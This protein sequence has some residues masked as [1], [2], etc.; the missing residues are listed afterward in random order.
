[1]A[2]VFTGVV[3]RAMAIFSE[4]ESKISNAWWSE[5]FLVTGARNFSSSLWFSAR[6]FVKLDSI[7]FLKDVFISSTFSSWILGDLLVHATRLS[8]WLLSATEDSISPEANYA[9]TFL[10]WLLV[11][12]LCKKTGNLWN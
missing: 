5:D 3:V 11:V 4:S 1:M 12:N 10:F 7:S 9:T 8:G 2:L 6:I